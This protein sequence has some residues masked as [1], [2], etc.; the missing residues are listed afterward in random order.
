MI[1][2]MHHWMRLHL[3]LVAAV[4]VALVAGFA[5]PCVAASAS[6][7]AVSAHHAGH[8]APPADDAGAGALPPGTTC[9]VACVAVPPAPLASTAPVRVVLVR[10]TPAAPTP[11]GLSAP[12][13]DPPPR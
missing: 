2:Q 13:E 10:W 12:P 4:F 3:A 1:R 9:S 11:S 7:L 8:G 6:G 5:L